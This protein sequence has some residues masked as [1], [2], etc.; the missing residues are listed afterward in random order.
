MNNVHK[1][2]G[3]ATFFEIDTEVIGNACFD[4]IKLMM[5]ELTKMKAAKPA[6]VAPV[7][8]YDGP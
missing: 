2:Q 7:T 4:Q 3:K 6:K 5:K 8:R 1:V